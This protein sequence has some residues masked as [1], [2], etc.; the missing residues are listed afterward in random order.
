VLVA[1]VASAFALAVFRFPLF[2]L[3][4][5]ATTYFLATDL[6]STEATGARS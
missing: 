2:V 4:L 3:F 6:I 5:A 1:V